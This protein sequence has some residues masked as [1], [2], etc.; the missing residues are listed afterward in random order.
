MLVTQNTDGIHPH[1]IKNSE[2]LSKK[3]DK[4]FNVEE[5]GCESAF[6]PYVYEIHG[7]VRYMHC[8]NE[9]EECSKLMVKTPSLEEFE[10]H[11]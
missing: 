6:T 7:N 4:F 11:R 8:N 5:K 1:L 10:A 2:I 9:A 3:K